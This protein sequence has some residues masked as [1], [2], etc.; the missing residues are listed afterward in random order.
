MRNTILKTLVLSFHLMLFSE[1]FDEAEYYRQQETKKRAYE[2]YIVYVN[3]IRGAVAEEVEKELGLRFYGTKDS[4]HEKIEDM[5]MDFITYRRATVK[6]ARA[7]HLLIIDKFVNAVNAHEKIQPFL[8]ISPFSYERAH[9]YI[10]FTQRGIG[11]F[12]DGTVASIM[13]ITNNA[14]NEENRNKLIYARYNPFKQAHRN[15]LKETYEEAVALNSL[16]PV[17]HP[18]IH[19]ENALEGLLDQF[20]LTFVHEVADEFGVYC[21]S[22]GGELV[23]EIKTIGG[24][25]VMLQPVD[26]AQARQVIVTV[27]EKLLNDLNNKKELKPYFKEYPFPSKSINIRIGFRTKNNKYYY[28]TSIKD[29][30]LENDIINYDEIVHR[31]DSWLTRENDVGTETYPEALEIVKQTPVSTRPS[32]WFVLISFFNF[33]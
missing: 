11:E 12:R 2:E 7:L 6:E 28:D 29:A 33:F 3:E 23:D 17:A 5:G 30:A 25:F 1:D 10:S 15:L 18:E 9:V 13:N 24:N 4:M 31:T 14:T 32:L 26:M 8:E 19:Q 21:D 22:I 20:F 16:D 27:T